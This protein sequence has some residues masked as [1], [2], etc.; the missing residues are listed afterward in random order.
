MAT[1][2]RLTS[3]IASTGAAGSGAGSNPEDDPLI[4]RATAETAMRTQ[5]SK[6]NELLRLSLAW[7]DRSKA[8]E[9]TVA[10]EIQRCWTA[11]ETERWIR[12][13]HMPFESND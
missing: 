12:C 9:R 10:E 13:G 5:V 11:W 3:V 2:T 7:Q 1:L 8:F 4:V 6:E